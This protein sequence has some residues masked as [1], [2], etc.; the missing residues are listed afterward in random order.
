MTQSMISCRN[1]NWGALHIA[2]SDRSGP[3]IEM[4]RQT[5]GMRLSSSLEN[6][7]KTERTLWGTHRWW[8]RSLPVEPFA[9]PFSL[10]SLR[11]FPMA[12]NG[13][14]FDFETRK[15]ASKSITTRRTRRAEQPRLVKITVQE[16]PFLLSY[17]P[18]RGPHLQ[19]P[20]S[21][22][23]VLSKEALP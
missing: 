15:C 14:V 2:K 9:S 16:R 13:V 7:R 19:Y 6:T 21:R 22:F 1:A 11:A 12:I 18:K 8:K 23:P 17:D 5:L 3:S 20:F 10:S 4:G